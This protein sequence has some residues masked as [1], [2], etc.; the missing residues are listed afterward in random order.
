MRRLFKLQYD[1]IL[2]EKNNGDVDEEESSQYRIQEME[3]R[4]DSIILEK[5][6]TDKL[7]NLYGQ[8]TKADEYVEIFTFQ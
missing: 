4:I 7:S 3:D 6:K 8:Y 1:N 2:K 5:A